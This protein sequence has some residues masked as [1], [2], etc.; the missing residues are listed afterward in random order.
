MAVETAERIL[1]L[2]RASNTSVALLDVLLPD[3]PARSYQ[4]TAAMS[5]EPLGRVRR[6]GNDAGYVVALEARPVDSCR[7]LRVLSETMPWIDPATVV[8][9]VDTRPRAIVRKG[10]GNLV[11]EWDGALLIGGTG[12]PR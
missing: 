12:A 3:R 9:L 10:R 4:R 6:L 7:E 11:V 5:G 8:P 1:G 2:S